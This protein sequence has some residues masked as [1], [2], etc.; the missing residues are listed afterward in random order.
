MKRKA[1]YFESLP[2]SNVICH[3]CPAECH[4]KDGKSGICGCRR[5]AGGELVTDNYGE[6][7]TLATDPIE[8]KPLY[9]FYPGSQILSTGANGCNFGCLHCQNWMISQEKTS[10]VSVMPE[11]L[12]TLAG[13]EGSIGIAFTYTEPMIWYEYI[14]DSAPLLRQAGYKVVLVSNG[15]INPEPLDNLVELIDAVNIDLKGIR[16]EFYK[17]VCKGKIEP[18]LN[19]IRRVKESGVHLELTNLLI[20]GQN[21]S[22]LDIRNLVEF[23]ASVSD[24]I[25]LHLSA[26]HPAHKLKTGATDDET[27]LKAYEIAAECLKFVY[28]GNVAFPGYSD[29]ICPGCDQLLIKRTAY[30]T[31]VLG[32]KEGKCADCGYDTGIIQ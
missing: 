3:L 20:P 22:D 31:A 10:T 13:Q 15:Y 1:E 5:N 26:Y 32:L 6:L 23:V 8:K 25:P 30:E 18:I 27:M 24:S 14:I 16:P 19:N 28:V 9:H 4:L 12:V 2:G 17:R 29:T 7:V 11:K 21:D